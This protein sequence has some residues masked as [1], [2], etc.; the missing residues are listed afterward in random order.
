MDSKP[1]YL[2]TGSNHPPQIIKNIPRMVNKRLIDI[3]S[4]KTVFDDAKGPY[5]DALIKAGHKDE[6]KYEELPAKR[7]KRVRSR[8]VTW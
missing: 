5:Q 6:L 3:S 4:N 1:I 8:K 2:N 7:T